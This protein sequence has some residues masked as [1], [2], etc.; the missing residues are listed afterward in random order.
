MRLCPRV[1]NERF[2]SAETFRK[3]D[4]ID[5]PENL[6]DGFKR[7]DVDRD[8]CAEA[9]ALFFHNI[10]SRMIFKA[11]IKDFLDLFLR[12]EPRSDL[13]CVIG[14]AFHADRQCLDAAQQKPAVH[15]SELIAV[16]FDLTMHIG[17]KFFGVDDDDARKHV[18]M[19]AD[20]FGC[21]VDDDVCAECDRFLEIG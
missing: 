17:C 4:E 15:R 8:H 21:T 11:D 9:G 10:M 3:H 6:F 14:V 20:K 1:C 13:H 18:V 12:A 5:A 7:I 16:C 2:G 19:P